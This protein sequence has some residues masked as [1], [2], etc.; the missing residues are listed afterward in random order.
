MQYRYV[1][2]RRTD[3][4]KCYISIADA[5]Y[6]ELSNSAA[7]ADRGRGFTKA[8]KNRPEFKA[9]NKYQQKQRNFLS[10]TPHPRGSSP[11]HTD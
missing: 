2:D 7:I 4:R 8:D 1:S 11:F 6:Q 9:V 5:R 3:S 10:P